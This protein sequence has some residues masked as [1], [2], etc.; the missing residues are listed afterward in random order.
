MPAKKFSVEQIVAKLRE[1]ERLQ[2]QGLTIPQLC[3]RLG[4]SDQTFYR[5]RLKY[6]ALKEDE[7]QRLKALE[8]ENSRLK[9]IVAEQALDIAMLKDLERGKW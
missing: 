1:A 4:I 8:L 3:K 5:W 7:A 2:G 9:R 6:G